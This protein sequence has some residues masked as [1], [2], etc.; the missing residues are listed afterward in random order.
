MDNF[1]EKKWFVFVKEKH[2]GPFSIEELQTRLDAGLSLEHTYIWREGMPDWKIA[3]NS[4]QFTEALHEFKNATSRFTAESTN[5][6][7][8]SY[9]GEKTF[10]ISND[11]E[12]ERLTHEPTLEESETDSPEEQ[13]LEAHADHQKSE[14]P[15]ALIKTPS[16]LNRSF[17]SW[18]KTKLLATLSVLALGS[19][20]FFFYTHPE[21]LTSAQNWKQRALT[22]L[23]D[24][25]PEVG[26]WVYILPELNLIEAERSEF[27]TAAKA[28]LKKVGPRFAIGLLQGDPLFP[29]LVFAANVP[30]GFALHVKIAGV[31]ETLLS[32]HSFESEVEVIFN[33]RMARS[34]TLS[35]ENGKPLTRGEYVVAISAAQTQL[36]GL[37]DLIP[38]ISLIPLANSPLGK[39]ETEQVIG[40]KTYF[41]G[42]PKDEYY[43]SSL[44]EYQR[45]L[46]EK[47]QGEIRE[48]KEYLSTLEEQ[49]KTSQ[50]QF[51]T[52]K[53]KKKW[54]P[55][56]AKWMKLQANLT[57]IF[58]QWTTET[59][60]NQFY[61][62]SIYEDIQSLAASVQKIHDLEDQT[63]KSAQAPKL[64]AKELEDSKSLIHDQLLSLHGQIDEAEKN[65]P[66]APRREKTQ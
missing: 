30:D 19:A 25:F 32:L 49:L 20:S 45:R 11:S 65:I 52:L 54:D 31:P 7:K 23:T 55:F 63:F 3:A 60:E 51:A 16:W 41:L 12:Q 48:L 1:I 33:H 13:A 38:R 37:Q 4:P 35:L 62:G 56:H 6:F 14:T 24:Q 47:A 53:L 2:E 59:F 50:A 28:N 66:T 43:M 34:G 29:E 42:G 9:A 44:Q 58:S 36:P 5:P 39:D 18:S 17:P 40:F 46:H 57:Q 27:K 10:P 22:S 8:T 64:L 26:N 15:A 61:Y 21:A